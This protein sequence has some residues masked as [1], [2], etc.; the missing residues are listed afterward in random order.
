MGTAGS[1]L[2]PPGIPFRF[3]SPLPRA[4]LVA[5]TWEHP[6]RTTLG[7]VKL[8]TAAF[9]HTMSQEPLRV[10]FFLTQKHLTSQSSPQIPLGS[11]GAG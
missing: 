8:P 10:Y 6:L 5:G 7:L 4:L 11:L 1:P 3:L 2:R 9:L